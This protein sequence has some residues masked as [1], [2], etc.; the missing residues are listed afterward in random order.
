MRDLGVTESFKLKRQVLL[1][2]TEAAEMILRYAGHDPY[3]SRAHSRYIQ[4]RF[5][6]TR[7]AAEARGAL[8][9][10]YHIRLRALY[11][12]YHA[13]G[14]I[15]YGCTNQSERYIYSLQQ[16]QPACDGA[17]VLKF[18]PLTSSQYIALSRQQ[19]QALSPPEFF[20]QIKATAIIIVFVLPKRRGP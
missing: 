16:S 6:S 5:H 11:C 18:A 1:S 8:A 15:P 17:L 7:H 13:I 12:R 3:N 10:T 4:S 14:V 9:R 20:T 19:L 2:A